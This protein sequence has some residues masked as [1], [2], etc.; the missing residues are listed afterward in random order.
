MTQTSK[1]S[2]LL[3]SSFLPGPKRLCERLNHSTHAKVRSWFPHQGRVPHTPGF[4]VK[5]VAVDELHAAFLNESRTRGR[6][7][8]PRTG[9]PGI[10]LVFRE[11]WDSTDVDHQVHRMN[12]ESEGKSSGIPHLA[13]N[14]RD[15]GHPSLGV[16]TRSARP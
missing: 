16:G 11:M 14:E 13:K 10:S 7:L 3:N 5:F 12:R 15:V 9:N 1:V 2:S 6:C 8:G 4:T